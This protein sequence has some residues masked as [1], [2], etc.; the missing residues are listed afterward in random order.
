[1]GARERYQIIVESQTRGEVDVRRF[2][3][4]LNKLADVVDRSNK[5]TASSTEVSA[6]KVAAATQSARKEIEQTGF[7]IQ[8]SLS[9]PLDTV[10][11][12]LL[13]GASGLSKFAGAAAGITT[14]IALT[15]A[16][17][18]TFVQGVSETAFEI[19][20]LSQSTGLTISQADKL[21]AA[22]N[23]TGFDIRNLQEAAL[24]LSVAL[25]DSGGQG[26]QTRQLLQQLGVAATTA[27][28]DARPLGPVLL[29]TFEALSKIDDVTKRVNLSRVLG[30]EDAAKR[31][32]PLLAQF[33]E[34]NRVAADLGYGTRDNLLK[35]LEESNLELRKFDAQWEIIKGKL[36]AAIAPIVVPI[37]VRLIGLA[38]GDLKQLPGAAFQDPGKRAQQ[39]VIANMFPTIGGE[40]LDRFA[41]KV[42]AGAL[43]PYGDPAEGRRLADRFRS[44]QSATEDGMKF[45]LDAIGKQRDELRQKLSS[46]SLAPAAFRT[47][48]G[49]LAALSAEEVQIRRR[50]KQIEAA[51]A[52]AE[53]TIESSSLVNLNTGATI[54][55]PRTPSLLRRGENPNTLIGAGSGFATSEAAIA[56]ANPDNGQMQARAQFQATVDQQS[57][58]RTVQLI[59]QE[60][61]FQI[62][63]VEL[64]TGP[65][66]EM[67]AVEKIAQLRRAALEQEMQSGAEI[68]DLRERQ[69]AIEEEREL[70]LVE[71]QRRRRE[72]TRAL[73]SE[74]VGSLQAGRPGDFLRQQGSRFVNQLG[75]N[76]LEGVVSRAQGALGQ[77]GA[78][79]GLGPLLAGTILDPANATPVDKNTAATERNTAALE[80]ATGGRVPGAAGGGISGLLGLFGSD[81]N[82]IT[83]RGPITAGGGRL[84][85]FFAGASLVPQTG[86]FGGLSG[87]DRSIE[88]APG[89]AT[90]ASAAGLLSKSGRAGNIVGRA[91]V[92]AAST[93]GAIDGFKRGGVGGNLQGIGSVLGGL[94]V[95]PGPQQPFIAAGAL[96]AGFV[97]S[98]LPNPK[99]QRAKQI[100]SMLDAAYYGEAEPTTYNVDQYGRGYDT[101]RRG[102]IRSMGSVAIYISAVDGPSVERLLQNNRSAVADVV[103]MAMLEGHP[104]N[105]AAREV[106][107]AS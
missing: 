60:L 38:S 39:E 27:A 83:G 3:D 26:D 34:V 24:D 70:R 4:T 23:L 79:T 43:T 48:D 73:T 30:G 9:S 94:S 28:G 72:E 100:N 86:L 36:A 51:R 41:P 16:G 42:P 62:Q 25:K 20:S 47:L 82:G 45:R 102:D 91:G 74:L 8:R 71:I 17:L 78:S 13:G 107:L 90:T 85:Q 32:Q 96:I 53:I 65:G 88:L 89:V 12:K 69:L 18:K 104:I 21:R 61:Q 63:K 77:F 6:R 103:G 59:G 14:A 52:G 97:A 92:L 64:L 35:A 44:G 37:S 7:S 105:R 19:K 80:R 5:R 58:Q 33:Q 95:I 75:T 101:N 66:G 22:A 76:A 40:S 99:V 29:E 10:S 56:A 93:L 87:T 31:V 84:A 57:R 68:F 50:M 81:T 67:A 46:G 15:G 11:S 54:R 55:G 1:M 2:S 49:Q 98:V 106:V